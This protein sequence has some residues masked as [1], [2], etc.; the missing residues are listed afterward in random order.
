VANK[1]TSDALARTREAQ[2][3]TENA[4][5]QSEEARQE[6]QAVSNF[7]V[8]AFRSPDPTQDGRQVKVAD[9]L[10]RA[11]A[12]I[13]Q[14]FAGSSVTKAA[15]L[16]ALGTTYVGL[17]LYAPAVRLHKQA[18]DVRDAAM[19]PDHPDTLKSRSNLANAFGA[20][21][22]LSEAIALHETTLG[23]REARFGR[24]H[25]DTLGSRDNLGRA[26]YLAGRFN[27]AIAL[28]ESTLNS[29]EAK[30]G[31]DHLDTLGSRSNLANAYA[32]VGRLSAA[33]RLHKAVA[34]TL[35]A[36]LGPGHFRTL[37]F[38]AGQFPEAIAIHKATLEIQEAMLGDDHPETL[39]TRQNL[40]VD[41]YGAG[42]LSEM[43]D[44]FEAVVKLEELKLGP[45]HPE[46]LR[47][48]QNLAEAYVT[49]GRI[50][51][52][53]AL[54]EATLRAR[55]A[56][57]G[58]DHPQTLDSRI[59]LAS[60]YD[61]VGRRTA[62]EEHYRATL[63]HL[64][65]A[66]NPADKLLAKDLAFLGRHLMLE[67]RWSEAEPL[68]R[69]ALVIREKLASD[70]WERFATMSLLGGSLL[71]QGRCD[72]ADPLIV[73]GYGGL[74]ARDAKIPVPERFHLREAGESVVR[75]FETWNKPREA[76]EWK[77]KLGMR[78][79]PDRLF[80]SP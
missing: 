49:A 62:A 18:G 2:I 22:R 5:T 33:I 51:D 4:L 28:H 54:N 13:Q 65:K 72:L 45:D 69:E 14:G 26:Y 32:A 61:A 34:E 8:D 58:P 46:T 36:K 19:G 40:A 38:E 64:R 79:L 7:L 71:G 42:Q 74:K 24:D 50:F 41:Y 63:Q 47:T 21:G 60:A 17:G 80:A 52:G 1:A 59:A 16:N 31:P 66:A 53:I 77:A 10:D 30:L 73:D 44:L 9:V 23:Q 67:S 39:R 43:V 29:R 48:R 55:Q 68:L 20:V 12:R 37:N 15:L 76:A 70:G 27:E 6:A 3:E 56:T 78:D 25:L 57:L 35:R 11:S 75:L